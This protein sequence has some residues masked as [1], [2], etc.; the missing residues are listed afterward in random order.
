MGEASGLGNISPVTVLLDG[1]GLNGAEKLHSE[2]V[3]TNDLHLNLL[4]CPGA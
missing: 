1:L 4:S 2:L 3:N